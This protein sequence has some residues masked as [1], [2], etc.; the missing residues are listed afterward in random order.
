MCLEL[1]REQSLQTEPLSHAARRPPPHTHTL[2]EPLE[3]RSHAGRL[4]QR[5]TTHQERPPPQELRGGGGIVESASAFL[6]TR[7]SPGFSRI[8]GRRR[9]PSRLG[10]VRF[11]PSALPG[12]P[13]PPAQSPPSIPGRVSGRERRPG[14]L[15]ARP[16]RSF[17]SRSAFAHFLSPRTLSQGIAQ[18]SCSRS[19]R[20]LEQGARTHPRASAPR[21]SFALSKSPH[22]SRRPHRARS[23]AGGALGRPRGAQQL[24]QPDAG[25]ARRTRRLAA[26]G[27]KL[28]TQRLL[29]LRQEGLGSAGCRG[30]GTQSPAERLAPWPLHSAPLCAASICPLL[31]LNLFSALPTLSF[32][33]FAETPPSPP[34]SPAQMWTSP[35]PPLW[36]PPLVLLGLGGGGGGGEESLLETRL[37]TPAPP[38]R[39]P[40]VHWEPVRIWGA[41]DRDSEPPS[42]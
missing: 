38:R 10:G 29:S 12:S 11:S 5:P 14:W 33:A 39:V 9:A 26:G 16:P 8:P 27:A 13:E 25:A 2:P 21:A 23:P 17:H 28:H 30:P 19:F 4:G 32:D 31:S 1:V 22:P 36:S 18:A 15:F 6:K 20:G 7:L 40:R 34:R 41:I 3:G 24:P 42:W 35:A 37:P